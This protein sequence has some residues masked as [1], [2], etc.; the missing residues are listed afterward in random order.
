MLLSRIKQLNKIVLKSFF[1]SL[2]LLPRKGRKFYCLI[3]NITGLSPSN[4]ELYR[5]AFM[6]K[7]L[8]N[9]EHNGQ[10]VNNER[11]EYLGDAI[12]GAV[13]AHE[14]YIRFPNKDEGV[15]T[16]IRSRVVNRSNMNQLALRIGLGELIK[17]QP[18]TDVAN[19]HIPGDAL[20]ALI[21]ALY[22]DKGYVAATRFISRQIIDQTDRLED[23]IESDSNYKSLLIEWGQKN[24]SDIDFV[25]EEYSNSDETQNSFISH[26]YINKIHT[27]T[28]KGI[29]KKESQQQAASVALSKVFHIYSTSYN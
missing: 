12:L 22:L 6:H 19:T 8:M 9:K 10:L 27:G 15:L 21:G 4:L 3:R 20:E 5:L 13:V 29:S 2:K 26:I 11:L 16:K 7:S 23:V 1:T 28:G 25:T 24:R 17:T 14:L 18:L